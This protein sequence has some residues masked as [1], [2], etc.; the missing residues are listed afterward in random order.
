MQGLLATQILLAAYYVAG[1]FVLLGQVYYYNEI[2]PKRVTAAQAQ[3]RTSLHPVPSGDDEAQRA[4]RRPFLQ[5]AEG[6][7]LGGTSGYGAVNASAVSTASATRISLPPAESSSDVA[8]YAL[9]GIGLT[10]LG[11]GAYLTAPALREDGNAP[12]SGPGSDAQINWPAQLYGWTS[13]LLYISS[14]VPQLF[15]NRETKCVG[16]SVA[17]F[18]FAALGNVTQVVSIIAYSP[19]DHTYLLANS[20]WIAGSA[21]PIVFDLIILAQYVSYAP[22]RR[23]LQASGTAQPRRRSIGLD[24]SGY[25]LALATRSGLHHTASLPRRQALRSSCVACR[26]A[27]WLSLPGCLLTRSPGGILSCPPRAPPDAGCRTPTRATSPVLLVLPLEF[28]ACLSGHRAST[29]D[30]LLPANLG[31]RPAAAT[32]DSFD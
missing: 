17:L 31:D 3:A 19:V 25:V 5:T 8:L 27:G 29:V 7:G 13:A 1:D 28:H 4:Q 23:A 26:L 16:L 10:A 6:E 24:P 21:V 9:A 11:I 2:Y 15:K 20:S 14:P 12:G 22:A 32:I 18:I 30:C